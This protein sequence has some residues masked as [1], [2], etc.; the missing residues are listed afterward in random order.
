MATVYRLMQAMRARAERL[1]DRGER[2]S[3]VK[4]ELS[5][6]GSSPKRRLDSAKGLSGESFHPVGGDIVCILASCWFMRKELAPA[7]FSREWI[8]LS[9]AKP[10]FFLFVLHGH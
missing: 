3:A 6:S 4:E 2:A 1:D 7:L 10:F 8:F 9:Y 5:N